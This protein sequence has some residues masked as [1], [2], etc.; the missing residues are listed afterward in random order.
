M[1]ML[2]GRRALIIGA[3]S[4]IGAACARRFA[5]EGAQVVCAD[6]NAARAQATAAG[7][8]A[9]GGRAHAA[10]AVDIADAHQVRAC[11]DAAAAMLGGLDTAV[12]TPFGR[13][14]LAIEGLSPA[15]WRHE[16]EVLA[17]GT[18]YTFQAALAHL[19]AAGGGVL[20]STTA[21][22]F[23]DYGAFTHPALFPAYSAAKAGQE[24]LIKVM[25]TLHAREGI[26][27]CG[28]QPGFTRTEG[29]VAGLEGFGI[30]FDQFEGRAGAG[31]PLGVGDADAVADGFVFL[32]SDYAAYINGYTLAVDGGSYA[33]RFGRMLA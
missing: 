5:Q 29:A 4:G 15:Q 2:D 23:G 7:I 8:V 9:A 18:L 3:G 25:A 11:T 13:L 26:R 27:V 17:S 10:G 1:G 31:M 14:S 19:R 21:S 33:S 28:V 12:N 20:L 32:A 16:W 6:L 24:M 30:P 22:L